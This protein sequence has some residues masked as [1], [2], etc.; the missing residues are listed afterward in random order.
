MR[1]NQASK[2]VHSYYEVEANDNFF[3]EMREALGEGGI[4]VINVA[5]AYPLQGEAAQF[6]KS[7]YV[8]EFAGNADNGH[9][10]GPNPAQKEILQNW[11]AKGLPDEESFRIS[12]QVAEDIA[13]PK[14]AGKPVPFES[15]AQLAPD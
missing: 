13:F 6:G 5:K 15:V 9:N 12:R 2:S 10:G 3:R 1:F 7:K 4:N 14:P 11:G 8:L